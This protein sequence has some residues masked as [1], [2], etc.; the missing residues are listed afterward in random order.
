M[1]GQAKSDTY[2]REKPTINPQIV[3]HDFTLT[4]PPP[5]FLHMSLQHDPLHHIHHISNFS[6][7]IVN[8]LPSRGTTAY[9]I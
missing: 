2:N 4:L 9:Y 8:G 5:K 6:K 1:R 3:Y 7:H